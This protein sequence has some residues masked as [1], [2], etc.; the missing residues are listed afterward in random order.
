MK[1]FCCI[2]RIHEKNQLTLTA[3]VA[4]C[5]V[6]S[7]K[8]EYNTNR[9]EKDAKSWKDYSIVTRGAGRTH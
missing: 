4:M 6:V 9:E 2:N 3:V 7:G 5:P 1:F 8:Y